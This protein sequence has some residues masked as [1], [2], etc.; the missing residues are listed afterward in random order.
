MNHSI[1][2]ARAHRASLVWP[3][4]L[5]TLGVMF[6]LHEFVPGWNVRKTWPVLLVIVGVFKLVESSRPPRP[7]EGPRL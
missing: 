2:P 3:V 5:I 7:P 4:I 6:L 1:L